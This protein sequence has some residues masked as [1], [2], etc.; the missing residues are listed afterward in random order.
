[1]AAV[2]A[3]A[4]ILAACSSSKSSS[5]SSGGQSTATT[6]AAASA[7]GT[8]KPASGTP[9]KVGYITDGKSANID[10]SSE[11]PSAQAAV[12]YINDYLGG[13]G[14]HPLSLDVCDDQQTPSGATDCANQMVTDKVPAVLVNVSGEA[15][16]L[17]KPLATAS[18]PF[19]GYQVADSAF[20]TPKTG[21]YIM[22]NALVSSFAGPA[23][24][25]QLAGAK[26]AADIT[27]DVPAALGPAKALDPA[28][29]KNAGIAVD[30]VAVPPG[31]P[32]M[33]PQIQAEMAKSPDLFHVTGDVPFC[34]SA[35]K[36]IKTVGF[37][38]DIVVIAQ[39][40]SSTSAAS[41]PGGYAGIKIVTSASTDPSDPDVKIYLAAMAKY[42]PGTQPF[43]NG[44]TQGGFAVVWAFA[45]G[46]TGLT[47]DPTSANIEAAF[48]SMSAQP[49]PFGGGTTFQCNGQQVSITPAVCST[50]ALAATLD[51]SGK[52]TGSYTQLDA[53]ALLKLG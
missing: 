4:T 47:T 44:V 46:M 17:A 36:A 52:P 26:K 21:S 25:G 35:L 43:V 23:K 40:I 48:A 30:V 14:G 2:V 27:I 3:G 50:G 9:L 53:A 24:I 39:C 1:M 13:V 33:T 16:S 32:D 15:P 8:P 31:T 12:K 45:R 10:N 29:Y 38:K 28:F 7:L 49:L 20:L 18:I 37:T 34:T 11:I 19:V 5:S 6:A 22:S 42:S 51:T 41:I